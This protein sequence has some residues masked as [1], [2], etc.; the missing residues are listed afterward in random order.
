MHQSEMWRA[1]VMRTVDHRL[2]IGSV[3][4]VKNDPGFFL[5]VSAWC[6]T[7]FDAE[8]SRSIS[9]MQLQPAPLVARV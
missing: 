7:F 3:G 6:V 1:I 8:I 4:T 2:E 5:K 9:D